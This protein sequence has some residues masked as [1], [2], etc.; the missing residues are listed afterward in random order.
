MKKLFFFMAAG[1]MSGLVGGCSDSEAEVTPSPLTEPV[2]FQSEVTQTAIVIGWSPVANAVSY[3]Y[4]VSGGEMPAVSGQ[5]AE[6]LFRLD[7]LTPNVEYAV[8]VKAIPGSDDYLESEYA[9]LRVTTQPELPRLEKPELVIPDI[10]GTSL[11]VTWQAVANASSYEYCLSKG[12]EQVVASTT[13]DLQCQFADLEDGTAYEVRV[14]AM[15][16]D[17][18]VYSASEYAQATFTPRELASYA[19]GDFYEY[20][21]VKGIVYSLAPESNGTRGMIVSLDE[22]VCLWSPRFDDISEGEN[23]ESDRSDGSVNMARVRLLT[24]WQR[25]YPGFAWV[26]EKNVDGMTGWYVPSYN[27]LSALFA[28]YNGG[29]SGRD[30]QARAAFNEKLVAHGGVAFETTNYWTSTQFDSE[31]SYTVKFSFGSEPVYKN[32]AYPMRAVHAFPAPANA[33]PDPGAGIIPFSLSCYEVACDRKASTVEL[34]VSPADAQLN[35][36]DAAWCK[37]SR[38]GRKLMLTVDPNETGDFRSAQIEVV[39]ARNSAMKRQITVVQGQYALGD[40]YDKDGVQGVVFSGE[41]E[42]GTLLSMDETTAIYSSEVGEAIGASSWSDGIFNFNAVCKRDNWSEK[43]PAFAWCNAKNGSGP[44]KWYL[45][46]LNELKV[47]YDQS[48]A[49]NRTINEHGGTPLNGSGKYWA[50][51]ES[52]SNADFAWFIDFGSF[53]YEVRDVKEKTTQMRVRAVYRY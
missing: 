51:N 43:Y 22:T 50:S 44:V 9:C 36:A 16:A 27:E 39:S 3:G 2:L 14:R 28:A 40:F 47:I 35:I 34:T 6:C 4:E 5:T 23:G 25:Y 41:G 33:H 13:T 30:E 29:G 21:G 12:T 11:T 19:V 48:T 7:G 15:P 26:D 32:V 52:T 17:A 46:A 8:W 24:D 18:K 20:G 45:P 53:S 38:S 10:P 1:L 37:V 49:I 31:M 42:H